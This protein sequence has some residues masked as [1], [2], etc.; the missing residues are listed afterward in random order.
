MFQHVE[1]RVRRLVADHL[2]VDLEELQPQVSLVDDLAVDSLDLIELAIL[3]EGDLGVSIP[4][5]MVETVRTYGD[6]VDCALAAAREQ[7]RRDARRAELPAPPVHA[8]VVPADG[9]PGATLERAGVLTPYTA[10][11]I[12]EDA[13]RAGQGSHLEIT[14]PAGTTDDGLEWIRDQFA[15]LGYR[16]VDV[17]IRRDA[18]PPHGHGSRSDAA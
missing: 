7:G 13:L 11:T 9:S 12:A 18:Q 1:P 6:L 10:E 3:L 15:W 5:R 4:E 8:H 2:G 17:H 16:G 14:L